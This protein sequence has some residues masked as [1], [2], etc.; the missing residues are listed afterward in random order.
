M[1]PNFKKGN[2][3]LPVIIQHYSSLQV[4]MLGY[5]N[6]EAFQ[7]TQSS[8]KVTFFSRSKQRIWTK[9]ETSGNFLMVKEILL[10]CDEDT[11]LIKAAPKGPTCHTGTQ[12]C[13]EKEANG[14]FIHQLQD[15]ITQRKRNP[16]ESSYT[17]RLLTNSINKVAQKVGEEAT[18]LI[19]EAKDDDPNLFLN[20]AADL[21]YHYLVLLTH[22]GLDITKV[23]EVLRKRNS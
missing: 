4:L 22:K 16:D 11:I 10:D 5:M 15:L 13:F 9:G 21:M 1:N 18:E 20:E 12:T 14:S 3:L 19:I 7:L 6:S 17:S 8:G 23:E 2:G